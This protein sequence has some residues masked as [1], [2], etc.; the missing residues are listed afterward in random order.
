MQSRYVQHRIELNFIDFFDWHC[1]VSNIKLF[2]CVGSVWFFVFHL[3]PRQLDSRVH[4]T[5][6]RMF[7][8]FFLS[9]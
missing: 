7:V 3:Y 9:S 2:V 8:Q 1:F 5:S 4:V 6:V